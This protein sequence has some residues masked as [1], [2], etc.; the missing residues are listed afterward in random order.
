M[1][2]WQ[3]TAL[4]WSIGIVLLG[5]GVVSCGEQK[6]PEKQ[7]LVTGSDAEKALKE[8][9]YKKLNY[10]L[11]LGAGQYISHEE[12]VLQEDELIRGIRDAI[13]K[14]P[15]LTE[16]EVQEVMRSYMMLHMEVKNAQAQAQAKIYFD[17][18]AK[19]DGI[20]RDSSGLCYQILQEGTGA[21]PAD[22][23]TVLMNYK[24]RFTNGEEFDTNGAEPVMIDLRRVIAGWTIGIPKLRE[25]AKATLHIPA[26]LA[27]GPRGRDQVPGNAT[28][29]FDVELVKVMTPTDIEEYNKKM[30]EKTIS[31]K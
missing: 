11:G 16:E 2:R 22:T 23:S 8:F 29:V 9:D 30:S 5:V 25:G 15:E 27:Y 1:S 10:A 18:I 4:L 21:Q 13:N 20:V 3:N 24:A 7:P 14:K 17:S 12:I 19:L 31:Q 6:T 28:L 26:E